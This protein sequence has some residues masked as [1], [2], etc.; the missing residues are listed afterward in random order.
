MK[1]TKITETPSHYNDLDQMDT[2]TILQSMNDE[3][4]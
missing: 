2:K 3:D 1:Y 4:K